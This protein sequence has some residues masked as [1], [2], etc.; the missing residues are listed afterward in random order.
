MMI[1]I[2]GRSHDLIMIDRYHEWSDQSGIHSVFFNF[3]WWIWSKF[4]NTYTI[5]VVLSAMK[6]DLHRHDSDTTV[7]NENEI[8]VYEIMKATISHYYLAIHAFSKHL[9]FACVFHSCIFFND[10]TVP[11]N[12]IYYQGIFF[13]YHSLRKFGL[14][15]D[16]F[17]Y[18]RIWTYHIFRHH[19]IIDSFSIYIFWRVSKR[20]KIM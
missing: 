11:I 7:S 10:K 17:S 4:E 20:F 18:V 12:R 14:R 6:L 15:L 13:Y 19:D 16:Y 9:L 8:Q 1:H 5:E 2:A 3:L